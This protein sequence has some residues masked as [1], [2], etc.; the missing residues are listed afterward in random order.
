MKFTVN[1]TGQIS[2]EE[3]LTL[4]KGIEKLEQERDEKRSTPQL[5]PLQD[6]WAGKTVKIKSTTPDSEINS[7]LIKL[8]KDVDY[9]VSDDMG[10]DIKI[11]HRWFK[12]IWFEVK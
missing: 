2:A 10:N 6:C 11:Q 8:E 1:I 3:I 12:K 4:T 5:V 9:G 7:W